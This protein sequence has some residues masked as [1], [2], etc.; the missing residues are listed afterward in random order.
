MVMVSNPVSEMNQ[1]RPLSKLQLGAVSALTPQTV[2]TSDIIVHNGAPVVRVTT[3]GA[4]TG[5]IIQAGLYDG[6]ILLIQNESANT[7]TMAA[8][9]T[10]RVANGVT[11]VIRANMIAALRWE[12]S[13]GIW[14]GIF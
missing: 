2:A 10:S 8:V 6:Q 12:A 5:N 13:T 4:T 3:A 7:L 14:Y 1:G 11:F 9:A